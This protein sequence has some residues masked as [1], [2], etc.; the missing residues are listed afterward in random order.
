MHLIRSSI[1]S[2]NR[3]EFVFIY[4][5]GWL[6]FNRILF[7]LKKMLLRENIQTAPNPLALKTQF[8]IWQQF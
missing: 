1:N 8:I 7:K 2:I 5:F 6:P 3:K 4:K